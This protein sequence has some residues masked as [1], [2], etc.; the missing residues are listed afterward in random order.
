MCMCIIHSICICVILIHIAEI[1]ELWSASKPVP[2][3]QCALAAWTGATWLV[4]AL[5]L[6]HCVCIK[7]AIKLYVRTINKR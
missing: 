7:L 3:T 4:S 2:P 6:V 5:L 1:F